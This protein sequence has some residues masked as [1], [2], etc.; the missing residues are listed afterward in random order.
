[1]KDKL[2]YATLTNPDGTKSV[3]LYIANGEINE[4][5][6]AIDEEIVRD[7]R[8]RDW[9]SQPIHQLYKELY[10]ELLK[11]SKEYPKDGNVKDAIE[12]LKASF[13]TYSHIREKEYFVRKYA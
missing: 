2:E 11:V 9:S 6:N 3:G 8:E 5:N 12:L 10:R 7:L 13:I 4:T 1:M